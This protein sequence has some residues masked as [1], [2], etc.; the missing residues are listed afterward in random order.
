M[1]LFSVL[2]EQ[3]KCEVVQCPVLNDSILK[4]KAILDQL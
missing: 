4:H 2:Q 3:N 1:I